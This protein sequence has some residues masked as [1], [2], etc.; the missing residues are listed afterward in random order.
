MSE[1]ARNPV[2]PGFSPDPSVCRVGDDYYLVTST[3]EYFPAI[4]LYRSGNLTDWTLVGSVL[5]RE[6]QLDLSGVPDSGG[7]YAPTIRHHDGVWYV[8]CT[9]VGSP[10]G[11]SFIVS[12][13]DRKARGANRSGSK[14]RTASTRRCSSTATGSGG[15]RQTVPLGLKANVAPVRSGSASWTSRP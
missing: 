12:T 1:V 3:F 8:V 9:L 13:E 6:G 5:N 15:P 2:I 14:R 10:S 11:G 7:I 4:A